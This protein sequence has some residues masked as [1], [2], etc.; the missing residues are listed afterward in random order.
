MLVRACASHTRTRGGPGTGGSAPVSVI[1]RPAAAR[2][3]PAG[4]EGRCHRRSAGRSVAACGVITGPLIVRR[5][6][7]GLVVGGSVGGGGERA[8]TERAGKGGNGRG[9]VREGD[10]AAAAAAAAAAGLRDWDGDGGARG[11]QPAS[12]RR[13]P[14]RRRRCH[15]CGGSGGS[16]RGGGS[17]HGVVALRHGRFDAV[18]VLPR[19]GRH[20]LTR[21][22]DT[23]G[24]PAQLSLLHHFSIL[25]H[26]IRP[27]ASADGPGRGRRPRPRGRRRPASAPGR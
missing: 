27:E 4:R 23:S 10:S 9:S 2:S 24:I 16:G 19:P 5:V 26:A 25:E 17:H 14:R 7:A 22:R 15:S 8:V 12:A 20:T 6:S 1:S 18:S 3:L 21:Q 13:P 11:R